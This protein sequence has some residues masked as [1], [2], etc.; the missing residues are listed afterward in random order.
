MLNVIQIVFC[1]S[2]IHYKDVFCKNYDF[3]TLNDNKTSIMVSKFVILQALYDPLCLCV[4]LMREWSSD[5][6][7]ITVS[8]FSV[9]FPHI[10]CCFYLH[11]AELG[12]TNVNLNV[13]LTHFCVFCKV[14]I[15]EK[16]CPVVKMFDSP[17]TCT[18]DPNT[19]VLS[20]VKCVFFVIVYLC[21]PVAGFDA[22]FNLN[23][24]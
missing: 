19:T 22:I 2:F 7:S 1:L 3:R 9:N 21:I 8:K 12:L 4:Y 16:T 11:Y 10:I 14:C 6:I 24:I 20:D 5:K 15:L 23:D 13:P 17:R 18:N